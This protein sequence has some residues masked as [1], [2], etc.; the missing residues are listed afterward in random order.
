MESDGRYEPYEQDASY[1]EE[2]CI[3]LD[4]RVSAQEPTLNPELLAGAL[5]QLRSELAPDFAAFTRLETYD[6]D[7]RIYR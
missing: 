3:R 2:G 6:R 1:P 7:H 5:R 4:A